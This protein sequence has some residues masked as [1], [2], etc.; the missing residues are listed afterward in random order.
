M[1]SEAVEEQAQLLERLQ[2]LARQRAPREVRDGFVSFVRAYYEMASV[3]TLRMR[4]LEELTDAALRHFLF[5]QR[6]APG[7]MLIRV[8]P[9]ADLAARGGRGLA[10]LETVVDDMPFL[11]DSL[12]MAIR[13]TGAPIDWLVHPILNVAREA[14]QWDELAADGDAESLVH[15]EF[16]AFAQAS[17]YVALEATVAALLAD[18]RVVVDDFSA[19]RTRSVELA[20]HLAAIDPQA[21]SD[22]GNEAAEFL[23]WLDDGHF[24]FLGCTETD[25]VSGN[26]G[27][28]RFETR[29]ETAL[30][31]ARP[32]K[33]YADA[34]ALIAPRE[35]LDKY[36]ESSRL[37][38]I[39][40]GN[41]RSHIHHAE[42]VDVVSVKRVRDDGS[43]GGTCRFIGLFS[44]DAYIDRP[45]SIPLMRRKAEQ[46]MLRSRLPEHS[47]SGKYLRE[48]L[49]QLPRDELFQSNEDEL[50]ELCMGVRALRER[51]QLKLFMRRD[52]YGRFFSCL[53][54]LPRERYSRELRDRI[55]SELLAA[56]GGSGM[57]RSMDF[58]RHGMARIHYIVRTPA[59]TELTQST[60]QIEQRLLA[61]TRSWR[62]QLREAYARRQRGDT[63]LAARFFDAFP[64]SYQELTTA[65]EAATDLQSLL[66]LSTGRD[67]L[68]RLI[69]DTA[70][71]AAGRPTALKLYCRGKPVPLSDVLPTLENFGLRVI[72]QDPHELHP[73]DGDPVWI[74]QFTVQLVGD[75]VLTPEQ[76]RTYF[77]SAFLQTWRNE[78]END[79]LNRLVLTAGLEAR[80][81]VCLRT[82][83]KYLIQTGLPY[84]QDYKERLLAEYAPIARL[85]VQLFEARFDPQLS[86]DQRRDG[87]IKIAQALD[88]ALD[89]VVTLDG[90]RV[91]RA[92]TAV[93]RAALRT[94]YFQ[95]DIGGGNK[96]YVS[97]KLDPRKVP[98]L[99]APLPMFEVFVYAPDVEG[100][101]LR[102]GRVARG[103]LRW[104]D[105]RQDFRTEVLGL[106]KAQMVKN[107]IIVP[108]GAKGGFVVKQG[109]PADR[110]AWAR[111]GIECYKTFLRGLL[112]ITDNRVGDGIVAPTDV[113]RLDDDDPYLVV[114]ADK[115]TATFSDI[116]NGLAAEY[117]FWLGDAFAS[118]GSA[119]YDHKKMGI[120][121][122]GAW[123][124]VKRHFREVGKDIQS[125]AFTAVGVGDMSGDVFGNGMLLSPQTQ[126]IAAFDHRHIFIDPAPDVAASFA[127]RE[128]LFAM[129]RSSWDDY[130]KTLIS[131]GGGVWSRNSKLIK[132]S[133]A[134]Q[135][136]L[137]ISRANV[138]PQE[139]MRAILL[140]PVDLLWN[141][142]IGTYVKSHLQ[143]H[144]ECGD[145]ANDAIRVDGRQLRCRVVGEGG[146]LGCTQL[147][148]I[149][150][151]LDGSGGAGGRINTDFIDNA[152]GVHTSDREVNI[153]I[154]L[155]RLMLEGELT[156]E[157]RD[158]LLAKM[159]GDIGEAVLAD[160]YVQSLAISLIERDAASQLGEHNEVMRTLERD[161]Q[162]NRSVE[163]LPDDEALKERRARNRGLTRPELAV[164]LS[165][166][167]ISLFDSLLQS[168]V[169]DEPFFDRDLLD[170]FPHEL[171]K[172]QRDLLLR[173]RLRREIIA[174][175]LANA[176]VNRMGF[177]FTHRFADDH[178]V[179]RAEVVKAYAIAHEIYD[180]DR[181]W[182]PIQQL[183]NALPAATQLRLFGRAIGLMKHVTT[184]LLNYR[185][186][187]RP[188][189]EAVAGFGKGIDNLTAMLPDVLPGSYRGDWEKAV[190]AMLADGVPVGIANQLANTM[191]LGSALDI[192]EIAGDAKLP[193]DEAAQAYF[194]VGDRLNMLWLL[195]TIIAFPV[196]S[197]WQALARSNLREDSYRLHRRIAA[198]VL[199]MP[200]ASAQARVDAWLL[201][202]P[203]K[204]R[205][206]IQRLHDLQASGVPDF[207]T[208]AVA[209]RELRKLSG[210]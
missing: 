57:D 207:M 203:A 82:L 42:F 56:C 120:T 111:Q 128:R 58:L 21:T 43:I 16:E 73:K 198:R 34:D 55:G 140:A 97:I 69:V 122:R 138:T 60:A 19:M 94:N 36:S 27:R 12:S 18:I 66:Q 78:T 146:N 190:A 83:T 39:T 38:V 200:G 41:Q 81:V 123:E 136:A 152:G 76:Q 113:V 151:A 87:E 159:T 33:R 144:E 4:S 193:L 45:R 162:L 126:L 174:T 137:G 26:D 100:I 175:I 158:P 121:A 130:D 188:I 48:I 23:R 115:G 208:L 168:G 173:H 64:T 9:P 8:L 210:L 170:Y 171:V 179:P 204:L 110:E 77:E 206:G 153:K 183:D 101:H 54:F 103:G 91:L 65:D 68:P 147:G 202:N 160:N 119:G 49:Y 79:G 189:D 13:D 61:A 124:S 197:K 104:S 150:Y 31:L 195:S 25:V 108:V 186:T 32:G 35:E 96:R 90:D 5:A 14:Q 53:V 70:G 181:Y 15:I 75:C 154:P 114:A 169:P 141:G 47:H 191:V 95:K 196:Q 184:W 109:D 37:V 107:A 50:F 99:P 71:A 134:A 118:G 2:D 112:D 62:E 92:Y 85:L 194:L 187:D 182:L 157:V 89:K 52:R 30:G 105:R 24:T 145:R 185:W 205:F 165:Y 199:Q 40:K 156:R 80:Q 176:V 98:E 117:N 22:D 178:G 10:R 129:P 161:N 201:G 46:V 106:M 148:R 67:L 172:Q 116:A 44:A 180:G 1:R 74:Q 86:A 135:N 29:P 163:Y 59:G 84:S 3:D 149:E 93:V 72:S 132:L 164:L 102:G 20:R 192:I 143:S 155:N 167:K 139:L 6:R 63:V 142:G 166:S 127:E 17:G 7:E 133:E 177:S 11:V 131:E 209:V 125:E 28:P 51:A 88:A